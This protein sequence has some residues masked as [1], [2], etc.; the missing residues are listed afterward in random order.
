MQIKTEYLFGVLI[1]VYYSIK[2]N[3]FS[4]YKINIVCCLDLKNHYVYPK[5]VFGSAM[6]SLCMFLKTHV[7]ILISNAVVIRDV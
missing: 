4:H 6:V 5:F 2:V 3:A 7:L 1:R